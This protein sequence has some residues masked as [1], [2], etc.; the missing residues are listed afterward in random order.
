M[1]R[2]IQFYNILT[3]AYLILQLDFIKLN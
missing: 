3:D 1:I 2:N